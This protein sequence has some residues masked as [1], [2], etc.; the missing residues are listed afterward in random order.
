M[1]FVVELLF[2]IFMMQ[3]K[4]LMFFFGESITIRFWFAFCKQVTG[5]A[6]RSQPGRSVRCARRGG[7]R[8]SG[9]SYLANSFRGICQEI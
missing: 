2:N 5:N 3:F 8:G 9:R 1:L 4:N 6:N 7:D